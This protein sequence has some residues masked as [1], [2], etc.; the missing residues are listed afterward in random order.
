MRARFLNF[1][2]IKIDVFKLRLYNF[3]YEIMLIYLILIIQPL[4]KKENV[5]KVLK[6]AKKLNPKRHLMSTEKKFFTWENIG[7]WSNRNAKRK[8]DFASRRTD[9]ELFKRLWILKCLEMASSIR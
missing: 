7:G 5:K 3:G 6:K 4:R 8:S 9:L 1:R 2:L